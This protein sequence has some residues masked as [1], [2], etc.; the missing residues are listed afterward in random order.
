M[1]P[2][3]GGL[4]GDDKRLPARAFIKISKKVGQEG[5]K[6]EKRRS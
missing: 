4:Q 5:I 2:I 6:I 1:A 3:I